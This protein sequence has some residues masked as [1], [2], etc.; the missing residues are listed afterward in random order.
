[1]GD[2]MQGATLI[3]TIGFASFG[4]GTVGFFLFLIKAVQ[5]ALAAG[6]DASD[7]RSI[8][9]R[10]LVG[11]AAIKELFTWLKTSKVGFLSAILM[12]LGFGTFLG[13]VI[14]LSN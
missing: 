9:D 6:L 7:T 13:L 3:G 10:G 14:F 4:L 8:H 12:G 5:P 2:T 1:M 11:N